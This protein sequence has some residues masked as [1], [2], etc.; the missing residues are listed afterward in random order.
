M[1][2][3]TNLDRDDLLILYIADFIKSCKRIHL[4][5]NK[6]YIIPIKL[7]NWGTHLRGSFKWS[8]SVI[9]FDGAEYEFTNREIDDNKFIYLLNKALEQSKVR[10]KVFFQT[11]GD[12]YWVKKET[13]FERL[14]I[15]ADSCK[16]FDK[17]AKMIQKYANKT[18][19]PTDI[20]DVSVCGKRSSWSDSR[21]YTYLCYDADKCNAIIDYIR[22]NRSS[23]DIMEVVVEEYFSH[24]DDADYQCAM[25]QESEWY[26]CRGNKL[27]IKITTPSGKAKAMNRWG[28][29]RI[30]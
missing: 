2:K 29:R 26:G 8:R 21:D 7:E 5:S 4:V 17:L 30:Y 22:N 13:R 12:G 18:I 11:Y 23:R 27:L 3:V 16:E 20:F 6:S 10:G 19:E 1:A 28:M 14:E 24:G 25:Y 9:K 15:Y